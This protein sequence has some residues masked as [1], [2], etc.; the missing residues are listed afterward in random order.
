MIL[1]V[2]ATI[3]CYLQWH[4]VPSLTGYN[5]LQTFIIEYNTE[6]QVVKKNK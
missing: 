3:N 1:V 2:I 4:I 6:Y 5:Q